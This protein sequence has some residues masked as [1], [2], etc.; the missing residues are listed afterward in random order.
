MN[1]SGTAIAQRKIDADIMDSFIRDAHACVPAAKER[2][3]RELMERVIAD[4]QNAV[5]TGSAEEEHDLVHKAEVLGTRPSSYGLDPADPSTCDICNRFARTK[6][7]AVGKLNSCFAAALETAQ[8]AGGGSTDHKTLG[9]LLHPIEK[10]APVSRKI[11]AAPRDAAARREQNHTDTIAANNTKITKDNKSNTGNGGGSKKIMNRFEAMLASPTLS[12]KDLA[13]HIRMQTAI[14]RDKANNLRAEMMVPEVRLYDELTTLRFR[15]PGPDEDNAFYRDFCATLSAASGTPIPYRFFKGELEQLLSD[16]GVSQSSGSVPQKQLQQTVMNLSDPWRIQAYAALCARIAEASE[17]E[18]PA[19]AAKAWE[20][21]F[22]LYSKFFSLAKAED[23]TTYRQQTEDKFKQDTVA[24]W[25]GFLQQVLDKIIERTKG[26]I[27]DKKPESSKACISALG[28]KSLRAVDA[29]AANRVAGSLMIS[30]VNSI[31]TAATLKDAAALY[32]AIPA[33][34]LK[35]DSRSECARAMLDAMEKELDRTVEKEKDR[36]VAL[37]IFWMNKLKIASLYSS[38]SALVKKAVS[39]FYEKCTVYFNKVL[40]GYDSSKSKYSSSLRFADSLISLLPDDYVIA[41]DQNGNQLKRKDLMGYCFASK[42]KSDY[43]GKMKSI[44]SESEAKSLGQTIHNVINRTPV[45]GCNRTE[46][47]KYLTKMTLIM[48]ANMLVEEEMEPA[49]QLA[50]LESFPDG[51]ST[52]EIS[53]N[54]TKIRTVG[55]YKALIRDLTTPRVDPALQALADFAQADVGSTD[56]LRSF[57]EITEHA[58]KE[59]NRDVNGTR[60]IE[61]ADNCCRQVIVASINKKDDVSDYTFRSYYV[62]AIGIAASFLPA[63]YQLPI[64]GGK[65]MS[66]E[67][68]MR[69]L[70][71]DIAISEYTRKQAKAA[72]SSKVKKRSDEN[73]TTKKTEKK[74]KVKKEKISNSSK[75]KTTA[76]VAILAVLVVDLIFII[77]WLILTIISAVNGGLPIGWGY[78]RMLFGLFAIFCFPIALGTGFLNSGTDH[79]HLWT[80]IKAQ[81]QMLVAPVTLIASLIYFGAVPFPVWAT[82]LLCFYGVAYII[83]SLSMLIRKDD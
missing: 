32:E 78:V 11:A 61:Y 30:Y 67:N 49:Y 64:G 37:V 53:I 1:G 20:T 68:L 25:N 50:F 46:L 5:K 80:N 48:M 76:I 59:P 26:Y 54:G 66:I 47:L 62:P 19:H 17:A 12:S 6:R 31:T 52:D 2:S 79:E 43:E 3:R 27:R 16:M 39:D 74:E 42:L 65:T 14:P 28:M 60:Y 83:I 70:N 63:G 10:A 33:D 81:G 57:S 51:M 38:G 21:A 44:R 72:R 73:R 55:E 15:R 34:V 9:E 58:I 41:R 23:S 71:I 56:W 69:L 8:N 24:A 36:D 40:N 82:V 4:L 45:T 22:A 18:D 35:Q 7:V 75:N 13:M 29:D 77:P